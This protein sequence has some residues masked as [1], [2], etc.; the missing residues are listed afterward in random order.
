MLYQLSYTP[1]ANTENATSRQTYGA[2]G[3]R[4]SRVV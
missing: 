3:I 2:E 1:S 4:Q